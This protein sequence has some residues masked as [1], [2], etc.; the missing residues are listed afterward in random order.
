MNRTTSHPN[1]D[2]ASADANRR[3]FLVQAGTDAGA[4]T[5][6]LFLN[7]KASESAGP[8]APGERAQ[9]NADRPHTGPSPGAF[10]PNGIRLVRVN[11]I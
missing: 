2:T 11:A 10:W 8:E 3:R 9:S 6:G 7:A 4:L 5:A 1:T